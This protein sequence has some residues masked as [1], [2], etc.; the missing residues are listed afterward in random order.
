MKK[1]LIAIGVIGGIAIIY[2][3]FIYKPKGKA[4]GEKADG[5]TASLPPVEWL[6]GFDI[7]EKVNYNGKS[8]TA[9]ASG[10]KETANI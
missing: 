2:L 1:T 10:W 4:I 6:D 8:F 3:L 5:A 9:T 7:G